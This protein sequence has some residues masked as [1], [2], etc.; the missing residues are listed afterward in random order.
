MLELFYMGGPIHWTWV[1]VVTS[2]TSWCFQ[3]PNEIEY[4]SRNDRR[5][6]HPKYALKAYLLMVI[7]RRVNILSLLWVRLKSEVIMI[8]LRFI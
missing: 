7:Y 5:Q 6:F 4:I 1:C 2:F 3:I 8:A